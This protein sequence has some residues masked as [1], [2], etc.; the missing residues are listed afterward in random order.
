VS[1]IVEWND[2]ALAL[3]EPS[4]KPVVV[5]ARAFVEA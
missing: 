5:R 1:S 4:L 3:L 2:A